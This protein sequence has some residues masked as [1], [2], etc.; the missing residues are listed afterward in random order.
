MVYIWIRATLDWSDRATSEA[1]VLPRFRPKM[2]AW[3][4]TFR[5]PFHRFRHEVKR[6]AAANLAGVEGAVVAAWEE[7]PEGAWVL[8]VDDDDWFAPEAARHIAAI[9]DRGVLGVHWLRD[10][11]EVPIDLGHEIF[12]WRQRWFGTAPRWRCNTNDYAMRKTEAHRLPLLNHVQAS[13]WFD[14]PPPA[15]A[16]HLPARLSRTNRHLG[17]QTSLGFGRPSIGRRE[18]LRKYRR[19]RRLYASPPTG[20]LAWSAGC[21]AAMHDLMRALEPR[22]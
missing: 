9:E 2:E 21:V 1:L 8:P 18:L 13:A 22:G 3:N 17:S 15:P 4:A 12:L 5:M 16:L 19:Y 7:I 11:L 10:N 20:D 6:I 14:G